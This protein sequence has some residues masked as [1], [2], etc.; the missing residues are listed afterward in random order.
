[1]I[2]NTIPGHYNTKT[3]YYWTPSTW[4]ITAHYT[5]TPNSRIGTISKSAFERWK[6]ET[7]IPEFKFRKQTISETSKMIM[8]L[9]NSETYGHKGCDPIFVKFGE[10][11]LVG[12]ITY[13]IN[14]SIETGIFLGQWKLACV[15]P[16]LKSTDVYKSL[17]GSFQPMSQLPLVSKLT[18]WALQVQLLEFLEV[19]G[20]L[21]GNNHAYRKGLSTTTAVLQIMDYISQATDD[22]LFTAT[23]RIDQSAAFDCVDHSL[24][25]Q[26]LEHYRLG[27]ECINWIKSY[28]SACSCYVAI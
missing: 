27:R 16:L 15:I 18:E 9:K 1:M 20:Q 2:D 6:P 4:I 12:P 10:K 7:E 22:N 23:L 26:K 14:L 3:T 25:V 5:V 24:L 13:V 17:P 21:S 11:H 8:E 19:T 28:L